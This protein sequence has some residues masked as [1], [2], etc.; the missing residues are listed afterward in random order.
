MVVRKFL[1][2]PQYFVSIFPIIFVEKSKNWYDLTIIFSLFVAF[3]GGITLA[4]SSVMICFYKILG[5]RH[6]FS[7]PSNLYIYIYTTLLA[8]QANYHLSAFFCFMLSVLCCMLHIFTYKSHEPCCM[9]RLKV[10]GQ[11]ST[12]FKSWRSIFHLTLVTIHQTY[13]EGRISL[14]LFLLLW[15]LYL[16]FKHYSVVIIC[17][18][19]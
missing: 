7:Y 10:K 15:R 16:N 1:F 18:F 12:S 14:Q 4:F 13:H 3:L 9:I 6:S 5:M 19:Y 17:L 11:K 2:I 8:E